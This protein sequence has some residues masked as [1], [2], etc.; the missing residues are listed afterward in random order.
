MVY[1]TCPPGCHGICDDTMIHEGANVND[2]NNQTCA[3]LHWGVIRQQASV[4]AELLHAGADTSIRN[5]AGFT[6]SE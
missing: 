6:I 1:T 5:G 2:A 3:S 4:M